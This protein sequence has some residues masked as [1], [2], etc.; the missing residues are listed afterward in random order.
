MDT[1]S[2]AVLFIVLGG[3]VIS[4]VSMYWRIMVRGDFDRVPTY[5][6][7]ELSEENYASRISSQQL[8]I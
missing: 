1:K 3:V 2:K 5:P 6:E 4:L 8:L 7:E